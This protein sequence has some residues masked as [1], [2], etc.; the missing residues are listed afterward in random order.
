VPVALIDLDAETA[1]LLR[2]NIAAQ[3]DPINSDAACAARH[4]QWQAIAALDRRMRE[5]ARQ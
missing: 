4:E 1:A 5:R 3:V 2:L